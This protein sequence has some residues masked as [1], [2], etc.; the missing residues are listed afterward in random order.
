VDDG[1]DVST[2]T[3]SSSIH[4]Q[5][6]ETLYAIN[7]LPVGWQYATGAT[8]RTVTPSWT[9]SRIKHYIKKHAQRDTIIHLHWVA[10]FAT[11]RVIGWIAKRYPTVWTLH[12]CWPVTGD[13]HYPFEC[14]RFTDSCG[15]CPALGSSTTHDWSRISADWK[16]RSYGEHPIEYIAPSQW[17]ADQLKKSEIVTSDSVTVI[18]N[19]LD[20]EQFV[21]MSQN[22]A[23]KIIGLPID[24]VLIGFNSNTENRRKGGD[25]FKQALSK[26]EEFDQRGVEVVQFGGGEHGDLPLQTHD[27][28][29]VPDSRLAALYSSLD[30]M[31]VPSRYETFG[32][33]ASEAISC[34]TPVAAFDTSGLGSVVAEGK[35]GA[36]ASPF[37]CSELREAILR[38]L[39]FNDRSEQLHDIAERRFSS[40]VVANQHLETY[41]TIQTRASNG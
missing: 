36:L 28:G 5:F 6:G 38:V 37:D 12:D 23:R 8:D 30:A 41:R 10:G 39:D 2:I 40:S 1:G 13:C 29:Y 19:P 33:V 32:Q 35:T 3:G 21:P 27:L 26:Y 7:H 31:I 17:A 20:T 22:E 24:S 34:G 14:E 11:P 18:P 16:R 25:L 15:D 9:P 4:Q